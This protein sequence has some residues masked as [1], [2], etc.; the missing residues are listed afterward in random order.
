M[1]PIN[2]VEVKAEKLLKEHGRITPDM[3]TNNEL[4]Q[5]IVLKLTGKDIARVAKRCYA[6]RMKNKNVD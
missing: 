3:F 2:I 5:L 4:A 1:E 6:E